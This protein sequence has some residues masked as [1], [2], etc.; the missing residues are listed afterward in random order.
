MRRGNLQ[1]PSNVFRAYAEQT[2]AM[3]RM[4][5]MLEAL[6]P[7]G[8]CRPLGEIVRF[9]WRGR[10]NGP[11]AGSN[12][13]SRNRIKRPAEAWKVRCVVSNDINSP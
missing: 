8:V 11:K 2:L 9:L 4:R 3:N 7:A 12:R 5:G 6:V 10:S 13:I 1:R